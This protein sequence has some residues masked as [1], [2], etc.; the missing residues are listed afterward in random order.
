MAGRQPTTKP[1]QPW[2]PIL[3]D[4]LTGRRPDDEL[5]RDFIS[6][7]QSPFLL[8]LPDG[9]YRLHLVEH[10]IGFYEPSPCFYDLT[11][12]INDGPPV[13]LRRARP[14]TTNAGSLSTAWIRRIGSR[15]KTYGG[16]YRGHLVRPL[17]VDFEVQGGQVKLEFATQPRG[18]ENLSFMINP[19]RRP[20]QRVGRLL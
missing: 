14:A 6:R 19:S 1:P 2:P 16:K 15:T 13:L 17:E 4:E 20:R 10:G 11:L 9:K 18:F 12:R 5:L 7:A 3:A 8:D